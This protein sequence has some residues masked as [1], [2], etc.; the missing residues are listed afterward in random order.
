[1]ST[2]FT[3]LSPSAKYELVDSRSLA[4]TLAIGGFQA[5]VTTWLLQKL[6]DQGFSELTASDLEF[7]GQ[8][9]CGQ[10]YA[11]ELARTLGKSRQAVH[12]TVRELEK[13]GWLATMADAKL[14]NQKIIIFT[15]EGERMMS[16]ARRHFAEMDRDLEDQFGLNSLDELAEV[17]QFDPT[18]AKTG[19]K[20]LVNQ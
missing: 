6:Q 4:L 11:S 18:G 14:R 9:D 10:N 8:L 2:K 19:H 7:L 15:D 1:M 12:K 3:R 13:S 20:A 16:A 17:L 5:R